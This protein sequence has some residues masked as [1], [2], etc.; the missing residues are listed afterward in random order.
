MISEKD[1]LRIIQSNSKADGEWQILQKVKVKHINRKSIKDEIIDQ[2]ILLITSGKIK[3]GEKLPSESK[4]SEQFNVGRSS[5][6]EAIGAL[7][8]IGVLTVQPGRGTYVSISP[9]AFLAEPLSWGITTQSQELEGQFEVRAILEEGTAGLAAKK[10]N[11]EDIA[12][13]RELTDKLRIQRK[14]SKS[15]T[16][17]DLAFHFEIAKIS[18]N[19]LLYRFLSEYNRVIHDWMEQIEYINLGDI[20]AEQHEKIVNAIAEHDVEKAKRVMR[21]HLEYASRELSRVLLRKKK[22]LRKKPSR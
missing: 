16:K 1:I 3:S 9:E 18:R 12:K 2:V 8:L 10:A 13:L 19:K 17:L 15:R 6:R 14:H 20:V 7:S 21:Q 5:L 22:A 4:L 11:E